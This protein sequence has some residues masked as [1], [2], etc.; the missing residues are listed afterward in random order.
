MDIYKKKI[1]LELTVGEITEIV[2]HLKDVIL[3]LGGTDNTDEDTVSAFIKVAKIEQ[4]Y[5]Q[6]EGRDSILLKALK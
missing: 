1:K 2:E 3:A 6:D 4:S 5:F